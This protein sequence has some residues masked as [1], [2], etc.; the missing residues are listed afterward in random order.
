MKW[1]VVRDNRLADIQNQKIQMAKAAGSNKNNK[2]HKIIWEFEKWGEKNV[3]F[4]CANGE[5]FCMWNIY[6]TIAQQ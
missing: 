3:Q 4:V 6:Q 1:N 2:N 5:R